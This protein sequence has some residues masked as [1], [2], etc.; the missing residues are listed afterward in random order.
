MSANQDD[1][2]P[3]PVDSDLAT[4]ARTLRDTGQW[5]WVVDSRWRCMYITD[6]LRRSAGADERLMP[7]AMGEHLFGA[8][9]VSAAEQQPVGANSAELYRKFFQ[10]VVGMVI[11]DTPGGREELRGLVDVRLADLVDDAVPTDDVALSF[12]QVGSGIAGTREVQGIAMRVRSSTGELAGTVIVL[13]PAAGMDIIGVTFFNSDVRHLESMRRVRRAARR[14]SAV[15]F[16][17][18]EGSSPLAKRLSTASYFAL[19]RRFVRAADRCVIDAG[20]VVG[21]HVGDGVVA[22]FPEEL[23]G[24]ESAAVQACIEA[25]RALTGAIAEIAAQS[26]LQINEVTLRFGLHWGST[27]YLGAILTG[28]R[29]EVTALGDDVNDTARIEACATGGRT[30]ASKNLIERLT[31]NDATKLG[32]DPDRLAYTML[33]ELMAATEKARRD[34]SAIAVC[35]ITTTPRIA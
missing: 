25:S 13:K 7:V 28:G 5:A 32:L 14:P 4:V 27:I 18:L 16:A 22:F 8:A 19:G 10:G 31:L 12:V 35:D 34:A 26:E 6:A 15:L 20:G 30:L 21:R 29:A 23:Y 33:G 11:A 3:L 2:Y 9:A 17:D 24:S 1:P